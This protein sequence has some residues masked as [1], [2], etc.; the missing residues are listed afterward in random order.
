MEQKMQ[1]IYEG[2]EQEQEQ[3]FLASVRSMY[4]NLK[5]N[6]QT[7]D[8]ANEEIYLG[9]EL[10][11]IE[12]TNCLSSGIVFLEDG[13][14]KI[15]GEILADFLDCEWTIIRSGKNDLISKLAKT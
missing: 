5:T 11:V 3:L 13:E 10:K 4:G 2:A 1:E 12:G 8:R 7:S 6:L 15:N 14:F 9:D